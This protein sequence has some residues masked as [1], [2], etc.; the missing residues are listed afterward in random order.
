MPKAVKKAMLGVFRSEGHLGEQDAESLWDTLDKQG[1]IV[2]ET[3][4]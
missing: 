1:R 2:E 3:W 4:S